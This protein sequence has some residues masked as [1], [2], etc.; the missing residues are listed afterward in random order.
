M[1]AGLDAR[2]GADLGLR[3]RTFTPDSSPETRRHKA[4]TMPPINIASRY[5]FK[6]T[7]LCEHNFKDIYKDEGGVRL[8]NTILDFLFKPP[9][10]HKPM[11]QNGV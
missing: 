7:I 8:K 2:L 4:L 9:S 5:R 10:S 11:P 3:C 6:K 1:V